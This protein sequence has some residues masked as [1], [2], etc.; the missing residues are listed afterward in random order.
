[1]P[2]P[3]DPGQLR[4]NREIRGLTQQDVAEGLARLA[5]LHE[6]K[7]VGVNADMVSK[8]ERG[9]KQPSP[10]YRRLFCLL[11]E[12]G[13]ADMCLSSGPASPL[14]EPALPGSSLIDQLDRE[15]ALLR[16]ALADMWKD[17]IVKRRSLLRLLGAV[18]LAGFERLSDAL[19][20]PA[21]P[22]PLLPTVD[23]VAG[24]EVLAAR[25]QRLYD[26]TEPADLITPVLAHARTLSTMLAG[27]GPPS[28]R[29]RL[30]AQYG[31]VTLLAGRLSFFDLRDSAAARGHFTVALDAARESEDRLLA[32]AALGH[33]S[34]VPASERNYR[35]ADDYLRGAMAFAATTDVALLRSWLAAVEAEISTQ[36][37]SCDA[38][39]A[40]LD[41]AGDEI[42]K[43]SSPVPGWFD[44]Y[45]RTRLDGFRGYSYLTFG[46]IEESQSSLGRAI[47][48]L[49][50]RA[51][52]QRAVL[53][54][55]L[56]TVHLRNRD[57]DEAC[58]TAGTAS[59]ALQQAGYAT[60]A[61]RLRQFRT[62]VEPWSQHRAVR[63]LDEQLST[64]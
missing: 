37:G 18:P 44:Y 23:T 33:A 22:E 52:K 57:V 26:S 24:L 43:S 48:A 49:P 12:V 58:R 47:S 28:L 34:F 16:P 40:A 32:A 6:G 29:K 41:H 64:M 1:M 45:D 4:V 35:A 46:R 30:L 5:W 21:T 11:F 36:A 54:A 9:Q 2:L 38:A 59:A 27:H 61:D 53:L 13:P 14:M 25:Y 39:M 63:M 60:G 55:D 10:F 15:S 7:A 20:L 19:V 50:V 56:A 17:E 8:W 62:D 31:C 3:F 42:E 51:A